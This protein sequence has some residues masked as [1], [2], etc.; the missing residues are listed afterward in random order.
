[1]NQPATPLS[2][3][4]GVEGWGEG[5]RRRW[6]NIASNRHEAVFIIFHF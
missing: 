1:M 5:V 6:V 4:S 2:P 3:G